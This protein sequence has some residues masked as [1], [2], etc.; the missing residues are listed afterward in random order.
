M[1]HHED[2]ERRFYEL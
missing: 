2:Y 1:T